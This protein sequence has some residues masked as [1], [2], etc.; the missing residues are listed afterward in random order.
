M[1]YLE[2]N[3]FSAISVKILQIE[4]NV[5]KSNKAGVN[6]GLIITFIFTDAI[7]TCLIIVL[8]FMND[9]RPNIQ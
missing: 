9:P 7:A 3:H 2:Q 8:S 4:S 5:F 1:T 6:I